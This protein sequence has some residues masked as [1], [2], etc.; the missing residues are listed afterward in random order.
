MK[1]EFDTFRIKLGKEDRAK[2]WMQLLR[3]RKA[4]CI[5]TLEREKMVLETIFMT[6][7]DRRLYLSWFAIQGDEP[8][9]VEASEYEIDKLHNAFWDE[10]IDTSFKLDSFEHVVTFAPPAV[11]QALSLV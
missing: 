9:L 4:E 6:E 2:E 8:E 3:D 5:Q 7:K 11:Q 10:C 1:T